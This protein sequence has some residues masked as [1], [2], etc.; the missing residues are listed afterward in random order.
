[1]SS[2]C[3]TCNGNIDK[4]RSTRLLEKT[5]FNYSTSV[6]SK[7]ILEASV[8]KRNPQREKEVKILWIVLCSK[9]TLFEQR[10]DQFGV[11]G[12]LHLLCFKSN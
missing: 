5:Y 9:L 6:Y 1:M 8:S 10:S 11:Y 3:W 2:S 12:S 4:E 7:F